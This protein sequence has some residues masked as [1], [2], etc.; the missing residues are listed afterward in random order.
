V[1]ATPISIQGTFAGSPDRTPSGQITFKL[2]DAI[3]NG[4]TS[5]PQAPQ[6]AMLDASGR[7]IDPSGYAFQ[8]VAN[9]DAGT[10]PVGTAYVV[11]ARITGQLVD[12]FTVVVS[13]AATATDSATLVS[14]SDVVTLSTLIPSAA[15]LGQAISGTGIPALTTVTAVAPTAGTVTISA[16]ATASTTSTVTL[17]GVVMFNTLQGDSQ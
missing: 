4:A 5:Y 7:I 8:V 9:D 14:G 15:M 10:S 17:G 6:S 3:Y 13:E 12:E 16:P 11:T 2:T 1:T